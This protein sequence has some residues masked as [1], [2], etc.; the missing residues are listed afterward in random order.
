MRTFA[1][2]DEVEIA[3]TPRGAFGSRLGRPESERERGRTEESGGK[4]EQRSR[5]P[6]GR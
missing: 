4:G 5:D 3:S 1:R 6:E 2:P